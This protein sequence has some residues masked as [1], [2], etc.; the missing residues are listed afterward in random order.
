MLDAYHRKVYKARSRSNPD[1]FV[2]LKEIRME[3]EKEGVR[4]GLVGCMIPQSC[5]AFLPPTSST[6]PL[7][8]GSNSVSSLYP[9]LVCDT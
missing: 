3:N 6:F 2:A 7:H 4:G 5:N 8:M 9:W 1:E